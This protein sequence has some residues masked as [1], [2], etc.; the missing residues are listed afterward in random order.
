[1]SKPSLRRLQ[2]LPQMCVSIFV[3]TISSLNRYPGFLVLCSCRIKQDSHL[4]PPTPV[5]KGTAFNGAP[6]PWNCSK[7]FPLSLLLE[8]L[9][10]PGRLRAVALRR[11]FLGLRHG[12]GGLLGTQLLE[13]TVDTA[14]FRFFEE[15]PADVQSLLDD[16][17]VFSGS[18]AFALQVRPV[19]T[20]SNQCPE[21][22]SD[23]KHAKDG[24]A[25]RTLAP[26]QRLYPF[27]TCQDTHQ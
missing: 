11:I 8:Q 1:M 3:Q 26:M 22:L 24:F 23:P 2:Q 27:R 7:R 16:S 10:L 9:R 21:Q 19:M 5:E 15:D 4:N 25:V 6:L 14:R 12:E 17:P 20:S 18:P 13:R